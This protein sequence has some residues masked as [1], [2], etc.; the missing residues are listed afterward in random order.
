ML[1]RLYWFTVE[2]GLINTAE[3]L[4]IYGGGILSSIGE[5]IYALE[6]P[7]PKRNS[8]DLLRILR[9]PY[10]YDEMQKNYF[11]INSFE[12]L[13]DL[14]NQDLRSVFN[15]AKKHGVIEEESIDVRSC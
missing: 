10:R 3:G 5:S 7:I 12:D 6:S 1:A 9:T 15:E 14:V 4:R 2:F 13:F 11:I 8:F